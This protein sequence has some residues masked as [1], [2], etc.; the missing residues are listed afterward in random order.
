VALAALAAPEAPEAVSRRVVAVAAQQALPPQTHKLGDAAARQAVARAGA[1]ALV[2]VRVGAEARLL[3]H[4]AAQGAAA[5][6]M[7]PMALLLAAVAAVHPRR[8]GSA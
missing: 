1:A 4:A 7:K 6:P 5:I 2:Q 8:R 3:S